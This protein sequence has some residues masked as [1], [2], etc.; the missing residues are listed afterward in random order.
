MSSEEQEDLSELKKRI[1]ARKK[2]QE[3]MEDL[4]GQIR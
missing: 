4:R 2:V 3:E 1:L